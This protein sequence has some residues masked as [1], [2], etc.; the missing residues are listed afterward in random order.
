MKNGENPTFKNLEEIAGINHMRAHYRMASH[1]VHAN[2]K[3]IY[4]KLG[5]IDEGAIL[6]TGPSNFG[7]ADPGQCT[8]IS[9]LQSTVALCTVEPNLDTLVGIKI[10]EILIKEIGDLF[11]EIQSSIERESV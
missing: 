6:L 8:S 9:L 1:N 2:P 11:S 4:F 7:L 5:L 3:G 10:L